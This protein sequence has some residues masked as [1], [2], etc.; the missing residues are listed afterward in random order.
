MVLAWGAS[1]HCPKNSRCGARLC[2]KPAAAMFAI[3]CAQAAREIFW[4]A[5]LLRLVFDTAAPGRCRDAPACLASR[6]R[7]SS[8]TIYCREMRWEPRTANYANKIQ[9]VR[10]SL[11]RGC[12]QPQQRSHD[13]RLPP[14][15]RRPA[16]RI[17]LRPRTGAPRSFFA[18]LAYFAVY[19][20]VRA[21]SQTKMKRLKTSRITHHASPAPLISPFLGRGFC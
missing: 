8:P 11:E 2:S 5:T 1:W 17:F 16:V 10:W 20:L 15:S 14:C 6:A 21:S 19:F 12:P 13:R 3:Q 4:L 9:D 7:E 18:Y